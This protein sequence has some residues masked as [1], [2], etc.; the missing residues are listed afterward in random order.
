MKILVTG[1]QGYIGSV[2]VG[3]LKQHGYLVTGLDSGFFSDGTF[4]PAPIQPD[5]MVKKD[6]RCVETKDLENFD[7]IIHLAALSDDPIGELDP[8]LTDKIN[9]FGSVRLAKKARE[10]GV[11]RFLFSSSSSVYGSV[12]MNV[13]EN[14]PIRPITAY[15]NSKA[16][17]EKQISKLAQKN[18]SP[19]FLRNS[20]AYGPSPRIR[21]CTLVVHNLLGSAISTGRI[22]LKSDG[23]PWRPLVHI[24]DIGCA[25]LAALKAPRDKIHN[26]IYNVGQDSENYQVKD[27][28]ETI[29]R[30]VPGS[31]LEYTGENNADQRSYKVRFK[32]ITKDLPGFKPAWN[33]ERGCEGLYRFLKE[34]RFTIKHFKSR[35]FMRLKQIQYLTSSKLVDNNLFWIKSIEEGTSSK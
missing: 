2:L 35:R 8:N 23:T 18:F 17:A 9:R 30:T 24:E 25:F 27:I 5:H 31:V 28:A 19:V 10:A 13:D 14:S 3:Q 21:F 11:S 6:L 16:E 7:A 29:K 22:L 15:A 4:G 12:N 20:T 1:H 33:L 26:R 34:N 32:S